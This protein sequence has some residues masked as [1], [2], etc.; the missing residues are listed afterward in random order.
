MELVIFAGAAALALV[1]LFVLA[2]LAERVCQ[3][4][5]ARKAYVE[6]WEAT[7]A[8]RRRKELEFMAYAEA[9]Q[10]Q[11]YMENN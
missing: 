3:W 2:V 10:V 6:A 5:K 9:D 11:A 7:C 1:V 4:R 8:E